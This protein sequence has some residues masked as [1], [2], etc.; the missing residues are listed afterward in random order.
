MSDKS[1]QYNHKQKVLKSGFWYDNK[2]I[3]K[4]SQMAAQMATLLKNIGLID[5]SGVL[6]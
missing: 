1:S 3:T 4:L 2:I 5:C 6:Q